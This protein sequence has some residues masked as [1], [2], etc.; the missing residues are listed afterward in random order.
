[1]QKTKKS[2]CFHPNVTEAFRYKLLYTLRYVSY[3]VNECAKLLFKAEGT[4]LR[5]NVQELTALIERFKPLI[6]IS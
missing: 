3:D 4:S 2:L 6:C 5:Y 1:M